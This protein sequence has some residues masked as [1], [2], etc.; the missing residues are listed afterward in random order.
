[1]TRELG[2]TIASS[3][4]ILKNELEL[5]KPDLT[6]DLAQLFFGV[7]IGFLSIL[8]LTCILIS[9]MLLIAFYMYQRFG[10]FYIAIAT[11]FALVFSIIISIYFFR[12][13]WIHQPIRNYL[14]TILTRRKYNAR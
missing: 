4:T 7:V 9:L 11:I 1:M 2:E 12:E 14:F 10:S 8:G 13:R 6:E 3:Y 5:R